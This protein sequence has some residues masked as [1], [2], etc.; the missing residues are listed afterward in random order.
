MKF[1]IK[2]DIWYVLV[3]LCLSGCGHQAVVLH[4]TLVSE[5]AKIIPVEKNESVGIYLDAT[6]SMSG[7]ILEN[8]TGGMVRTVYAACLSELNGMLL[9]EYDGKNISCY[10]TDTA[11]WKVEENVLEE[12]KYKKYYVNS[13]EMSKKR[14]GYTRIGEI[15]DY[16]VPCLAEALEHGSVGDLFVLITDFYENRANETAVL[17]TL[18]KLSKLNN[19]KVFGIVGIRSRFA[20]KIYDVGPY[21]DTVEYG[22]DEDKE[23]QF[24]VLVYGYPKK[25]NQ[26][27]SQL[28]KRMLEYTES[29][30]YSVFYEPDIKGLDYHDFK[31]CQYY[32]KKFIWD[33]GMEV[34]INEQQM[35]P[36][37]KYWCNE[38]SDG[39][40]VLF[41]YTVPKAL[42]N[43][44]KLLSKENG[45][46][47]DVFI[48]NG[49]MKSMY[50]IDCLTNYG[51]V[52]CWSDEHG[53]F[54][55]V[56]KGTDYF[57]VLG[58]YFEE[59]ESQIY[60]FLQL[61]NQ[62]LTKGIWKLCWKNYIEPNSQEKF[63]WFQD[64]GCENGELD[65]SKTE[66]LN[67]YMDIL[68]DNMPRANNCFLDGAIY[69]EVE[70]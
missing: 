12:A 14:N 65:Y 70:D 42:M 53:C 43:D 15:S 63:G 23:R 67:D 41:A 6:P 40:T 19:D 9:S 44:F 36:V 47:E 51:E 35:L 16:N 62:H 59:E 27:C 33:Y 39:R 60:I 10:R 11:L 37:Y 3:I 21:A 1:K 20:G 54:E 31:E 30:E 17:N 22:I 18:R 50:H 32:E 49:Q 25:V 48:G 4:D 38:K 56:G 69:L 5:A 52:A 61:H 46:L 24:Y 64:W 68:I 34:K 7:F 66:R 29:C 26:I 45:Q 58:T 57:D 28:Q 2:R 13:E 55:N 8:Q